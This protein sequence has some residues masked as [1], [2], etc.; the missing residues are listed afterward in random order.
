MDYALELYFPRT[1]REP[2]GVFWG[3]MVSQ[4]NY[5]GITGPSVGLTAHRNYVNLVVASGFFN[6]T[7]TRCRSG[8]GHA[9]GNLPRM[10]TIRRPLR[11]RSGTN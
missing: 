8:N 3:L 4:L 5:Q 11:P 2:A 9:R 1:W 6:G 10:Y 7:V